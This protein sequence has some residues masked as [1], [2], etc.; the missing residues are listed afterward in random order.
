MKKISL[1]ELGYD[2]F[3]ESERKRLGFVDDPIGRVAAEYR[4]MYR[5]KTEEGDYSG[6]ITGKQLFK[7]EKR[8]DFPA[9]GDWVAIKKLP[10]SK[11]V[12]LGILSRKTLLRKKYSDKQDSQ[13]IATNIDVAFI[14]ESADKDYNINR[15]ER[16][17]VLVKEAGIEPII[18]FNKIDLL[19]E[20]DLNQRIGEVKERIKD[21]E[22]I[23]TSAI[24]KKGLDILNKSIDRGK[25]YCFLGS[26]GVGKSTL[27]NK[28]LGEEEIKTREISLASGKGRHTTTAREMYFL[29][30]GGILIDNPGTREVGMV[31]GE[32]GTKNVFGEITS[33]SKGCKFSN[34]SHIHE[35]GC[36]ISKAVKKGKLSEEKYLNYIKLKKESEFYRMTEA[37]KRRKDRKFGQF[38]KNAKKNKLYY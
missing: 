22:I 35:P 23:I 1:T 15:I 17:L 31:D 28:L 34:C 12:I 30:K 32:I 33:L 18:I 26:S 6:K 5:I 8:E 21:V 7:A 4:E 9:V 24:A 19:S 36:A 3:F 16:Y 2:D 37:E 10:D 27:I 11:A 20:S 38:V 13:I 25:T 29:E 14:V